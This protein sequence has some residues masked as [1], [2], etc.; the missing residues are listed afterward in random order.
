MSRII[1][2]E[3]EIDPVSLKSQVKWDDSNGLY[4]SSG[5][6][7][8]YYILENIR[9]QS[10]LIDTILLPDYLCESIIETVNL[11]GYKIKYYELTDQLTI[12]RENFSKL[13]SGKEAVLLINYFGLV[14]TEEQVEYI[15]T[16]DSYS[17]IILD[18]VQA[19]YDMGNQTK[20]NYSFTSFRKWF[21]IPDGALVKTKEVGVSSPKGENKFVEYKTAASIL[22]NC[23]NENVKL[24]DIY[25]NLFDKGE[26]LIPANMDA[27]MSTVS[28]LIFSNL[29]F[30][31]IAIRRIENAKFIISE[32][33][34]LGINPLLN[35]KENKVPLFVPIKLNARDLIRVKLAE[36]GIFC[37]VHWPVIIPD[38]LL[39]G[40]EMFEKELSIVI[41]QRYNIQDMSQI[42]AI[43]KQCLAT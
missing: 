20:A 28:K 39:K 7:A 12:K 42:I 8:L 22:K 35:L 5:R 37:P 10:S 32:L 30:D 11:K 43:I 21:P 9:Q 27:Q 40:R 29:D 6:A 15:R 25:L 17:C 41:D 33:K 36:K 4:Y 14:N 34:E 16:L 3:F 26:Q 13:Y 38:Q 24:D 19:F 31:S 2:G 1:G 23:R 18:N